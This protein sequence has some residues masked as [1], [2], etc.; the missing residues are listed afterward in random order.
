MQKELIYSKY[1][2][3]NTILKLK[4]EDKKD[5]IVASDTDSIYV[6][7]DKLVEKTCE[8]EPLLVPIFFFQ[9]Q[10]NLST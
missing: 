2:Y 7:L 8:V 5:Y 6:T 10:V 1:T 9:G 3:L 4:D